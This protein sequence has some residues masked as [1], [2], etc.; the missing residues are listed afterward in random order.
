M[1]LLAFF[2]ILLA[3]LKPT[4]ALD[5]A[6]TLDLK[7]S[8]TTLRE[9]EQSKPPCAYCEALSATQDSECPDV[10]LKS[11]QDIYRRG[12]VGTINKVVSD[13]SVQNQGLLV[14]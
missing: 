1:N 6:V 8:I 13:G 7:K 3:Y 12:T 5:E 4:F 9:I 14:H 11:H 10:I 2:L